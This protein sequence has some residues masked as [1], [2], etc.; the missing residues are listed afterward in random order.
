MIL[1]D[2]EGVISDSLEEDSPIDLLE[3]FRFTELVQVVYKFRLWQ[4]AEIEAHF[5]RLDDDLGRIGVQ[6]KI[7]RRVGAGGGDLCELGVIQDE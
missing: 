6:N 5:S 4:R 3:V 7:K 2:P 1:R